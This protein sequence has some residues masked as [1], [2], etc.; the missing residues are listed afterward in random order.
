VTALFGGAFDPVH[1]GHLM[2]A[3]QAKERF[4]LGR[5]VFVPSGN[6]PHKPMRTPF[7]HRAA[8]IRLACADCEISEV[9]N[10]S[11][12]TYTYHTLQMFPEPRAFIIGADAFAEIDTWY[13]WRD[14]IQMAEF[15]V[16]SRPGH[17]YRIPEGSRVRRLDSLA[18]DVSSSAIREALVTGARPPELPAPVYDYIRSHGLYQ[19][20]ATS[21]SFS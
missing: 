13:R 12:R 1:N 15:L 17:Q 18:L 8:M 3:Q 20:C 14:V 7:E 2:I 11:E 9:E 6:P 21:R 19:Q 16:V 5:V 4:G 10:T